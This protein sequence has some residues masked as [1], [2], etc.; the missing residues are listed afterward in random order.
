MLNAV[1]ILTNVS[2]VNL[3]DV[4]STRDIRAGSYTV[5]FY[6]QLWQSDKAIRYVPALGATVVIE[7]LRSDTVA[8]VPV[9]QKVTLTCT[10]AFKHPLP[11]DRSVW[12]G[13]LVAAD[14]L[15]IT[16]GGFRVTVTEA[17]QVT[18]LWSDMTIRKLPSSESCL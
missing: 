18:T 7:F 6:I 11:S 8:L 17:T 5:D 3:Y 2:N 4:V 13:T 15:K 16:T 9:S 12:K 14:I 1:K 10:E